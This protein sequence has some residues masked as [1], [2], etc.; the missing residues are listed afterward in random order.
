MGAQGRTRVPGLLAGPQWV[1]QNHFGL[2]VHPGDPNH[3]A[4]LFV[5][6]GPSIFTVPSNGA[7]TVLAQTKAEDICDTL[8]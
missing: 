1:S 6:T 2:T 3:A 8:G 4:G 5:L 7:I